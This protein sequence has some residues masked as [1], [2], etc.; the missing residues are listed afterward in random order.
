MRKF[1][2]VIKEPVE[3]TEKTRVDCGTCPVNMACVLKEG[4]N[5]WTF[6]CCHSTG[7]KMD[8]LLLIIDCGKHEFEQ[9]Q[10]AKRWAKCPLCSGGI[11][12]VVERT[13]REQGFDPNRYVLT[14]HAKVPFE[15]RRTLWVEKHKQAL[16][17]LRAE[18]ERD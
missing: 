6:D 1:L 11:M 10:E 2:D 17:R 12:E 18:N 14:V 7:F 15:E 3:A 8:D 13:Q 9:T 16:E 5:G 4:G